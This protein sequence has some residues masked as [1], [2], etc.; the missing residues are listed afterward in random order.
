MQLCRASVLDPSPASQRARL[1]YF[2]AEPERIT[3][4]LVALYCQLYADPAIADSMQRVFGITAGRGNLAGWSEAEAQR[5]QR[6][7]LV[8][9][10]DRN[11]GQSEEVG[12]YLASVIPGSQYHAVR[13]ACHWPQ[14]EQPE[15]HDAVVTDF[16]EG[17]R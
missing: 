2:V 14:W 16:L 10:T 15:A 3:D 8:L 12:Q 9:W 6:P 7:T 1:H 13:D 4:E 17:G 5:M 11:K